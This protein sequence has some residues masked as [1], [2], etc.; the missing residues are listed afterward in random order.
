MSY[1]SKSD[2][3]LE[4]LA[5]DV[6]AGKVFTDRDV[7]PDD[8]EAMVASIFKLML[9]G[10][11]VLD[12]YDEGK[13]VGMVYEYLSEAGP[14]SVNGYPSFMSVK[15]LDMDDFEKFRVRLVEILDW[16]DERVKSEEVE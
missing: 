11:I 9:F 4:Q 12:M 6:A 15:V 2:V 10:Q 16:Q 3:E 14:M 8:Y 1:E 5:Q 7:A 13:E